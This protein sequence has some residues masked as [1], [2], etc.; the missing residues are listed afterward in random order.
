MMR[1]RTFRSIILCLATV[2]AAAGAALTSPRRA[3]VPPSPR[4][5]AAE[6][7]G[8]PDVRISAASTNSRVFTD[9][10]PELGLVFHHDNDARGAYRLPEEMG[11][12]AGLLDADGDGD[13]DVFIAGGGPLTGDRPARP[14][15]LFRRDPAGYVDVTEMSG[16]GVPGPAYGVACA[17]Y[18]DDGDVDIYLTR[19]GRNALLR[20]RGDGTF[21][22]V[23]AAVGVDDDGFGASCVF[24]DHDRD[25]DLDLYVANYVGWAEERESPCYTILGE[26][27]YCNPLVYESP[28]ADVL[29]RNRGDGTFED[30][31]MASGIG[32]AKGNGLGVI[33]SDF[34]DDGWID[35][36]VANDQTPAFLWRNRGDGTFE[37]VATHW[38]CAYDGRGIAIAG[39]GVASEDLDGDGRFDLL[40][41][42]I[43][44]Q[45][46]LVLRNDAGTFEDVSLAMGLGVWSIPATAFGVALFDQDHDGNLDAYFANGDVNVDNPMPAGDN[47]YAQPDQFA[48]LENGRLVDATAASGV[49]FADVGRGVAAGDL[50]D[51]GDVDLLLTNN[52]GPVRLLRN[53]QAGSDR[54]LKVSARTGPGRRHAIGARLRLRVGGRVFTRE[55]RPQQSYL[56]SGDPRVHFGLGDA[57]SPISLEIRWPDGRFSQHEDLTSNTHVTVIQDDAGGASGREATP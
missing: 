30:V 18:D 37:N 40:V 49:T 7:L 23:A 10:A 17:D 26:R 45:T 15:R 41:T 52:G 31:S 16:A 14:C 19:L 46:N 11:P 47:R 8:E 55:V 56:C 13:L 1:A 53:E 57:V 51:D 39:M 21:E 4:Q 48:R 5:L 28:L 9:A 43:H 42:N 22:E 35:L 27:D 3:P 50:D 54:W 44:G 20:N 2:A 24:I 29:Y 33:A 12:G 38:G 6:V 32:H 34:D 36:Y 25:G